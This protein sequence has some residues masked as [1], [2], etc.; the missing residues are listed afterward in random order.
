MLMKEIQMQDGIMTNLK[1]YFMS[2]IALVIIVLLV[3]YWIFRPNSGNYHLRDKEQEIE[4]L[5][6]DIWR[7]N[8]EYPIVKHIKEL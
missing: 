8:R 7:N 4:D 2:E 5:A 6:Q 3:I 1:D